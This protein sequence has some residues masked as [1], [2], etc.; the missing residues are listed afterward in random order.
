MAHSG[1]ATS[2]VLTSSVQ[3]LLV[4][5][6]RGEEGGETWYLDDEGLLATAR[7]ASA[8]RASRGAV[9]G[10][11]TIAG[12]VEHVRWFVALLNAFARGERPAVDWTE[13]WSVRVV[14]DEAWRELLAALEREFEELHAHLGRGIDPEDA[15]RLMP[16]LATVVHVAYHVGA[17]RQL[18]RLPE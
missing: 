6:F 5:S 15:Q 4:E 12:H 18:L 13:S 2:E 7:S 3:K 17:V 10:G 14:D 1:M 11:A 16:V 8:E 9:E